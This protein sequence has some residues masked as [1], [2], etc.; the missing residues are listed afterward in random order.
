MMSLRR[1]PI[2][3]RTPISRV[4]SVTDTSM[5]FITPMPPTIRPTE[6]MTTIAIARPAVIERKLSRMTPTFPC[7][8][9]L[10]AEWYLAPH[11]QHIAHLILC[12]SIMPAFA[13]ARM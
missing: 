5:M 1:A 7:R 11:A 12:L 8:S 6:E 10:G 2:A 13:T 3:L 4:R 9:C